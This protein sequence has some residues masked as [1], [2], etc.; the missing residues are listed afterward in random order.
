MHYYSAPTGADLASVTGWDAAVSR[1]YA[2]CFGMLS[3][4]GLPTRLPV[5]KSCAEAY[6]SVKG[7]AVFD[8]QRLYLKVCTDA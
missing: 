6:D 1:N 7:T 8:E 5:F 3:V 2:P 4:A